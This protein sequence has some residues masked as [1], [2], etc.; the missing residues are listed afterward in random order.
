MCRRT[1]SVLRR[2][3]AGPTLH[4]ALEDG[5][6]I[7]KQLLSL[8]HT[9]DF[10][11]FH[12]NRLRPEQEY[13]VFKPSSPVKKRAAPAGAARFTSG[14]AENQGFQEMAFLRVLAI[15][16]AESPKEASS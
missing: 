16:S 9:S 8:L 1:Q 4:H 14:I 15:S 12:A 3:T 11:P 2:L 6:G 7:A 13:L 5:L 10:L